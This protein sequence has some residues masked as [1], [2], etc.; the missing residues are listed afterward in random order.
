M[1]PASRQANM[2]LFASRLVNA[3]LG[4]T[5]PFSVLIEMLVSGIVQNITHSPDLLKVKDFQT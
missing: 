5:K 4:S 3:G 2:G 1:A